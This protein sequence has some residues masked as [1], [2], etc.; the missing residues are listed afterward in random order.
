MLN[1]TEHK[2]NHAHKLIS[3]KKYNIWEFESKKSHYFSVFYEQLKCCA[4]LELSMKKF[5]NL[6]A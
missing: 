4:Q 3:M 6:E 5:Y 1:S 2:I